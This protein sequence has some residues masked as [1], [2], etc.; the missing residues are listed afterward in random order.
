MEQSPAGFQ[1][2]GEHSVQRSELHFC[3]GK[4]SKAEGKALK[5]KDLKKRGK[6]LFKAQLPPGSPAASSLPLWTMLLHPSLGS[7]TSHGTQTP[8]Q[9]KANPG[10]DVSKGCHSSCHP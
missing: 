8:L 1:Q 10:H 4:P 3:P 2:L 6:R 5:G 7:Q 9:G